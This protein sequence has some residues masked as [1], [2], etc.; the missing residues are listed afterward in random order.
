MATGTGTPSVYYSTVYNDGRTK[1]Q[2]STVQYTSTQYTT[3]QY[4]MMVERSTKHLQQVYL[5]LDVCITY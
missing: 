4:T 3:V 5:W 1:H 2:D